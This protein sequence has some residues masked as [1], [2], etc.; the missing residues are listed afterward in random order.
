MFR[1]ICQTGGVAGI[2]FYADFFGENPNI[3]TIAEHILHFRSLDPEG[4]HIALG[5]IDYV[6]ITDYKTVTQKLQYLLAE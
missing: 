5:G 4:S 6:E 3:H 1:A 2:N